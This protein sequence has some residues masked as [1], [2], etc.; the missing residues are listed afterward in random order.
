M[1]PNILPDFFAVLNEIE[2][3][4]VV[5]EVRDNDVYP[6]YPTEELRG[7]CASVVRALDRHVVL[8]V[9]VRGLYRRQQIE[10]GVRSS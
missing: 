2:S 8:A 6:F 4:G 3:K 5:L 10:D 9:T 1:K 7:T